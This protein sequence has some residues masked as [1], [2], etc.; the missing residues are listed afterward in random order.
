LNIQTERLE[1]QHAARLTVEIDQERLDK[2]KQKAAKQL[3]TRANIPGFRKGKAPYSIIVRYFGEAAIIQDAFELV[4]N[5][6]YRDALA[7]SGI[8]PYTSG[9]FEDFKLEPTPTLV[10]TVPLQPEVDLAGYRSVRVPYENAEVTDTDVTNAIKTLQEQ[11]AL[12]EDSAHPAK[13]GDRVTVDIHSHFVEEHEDEEVEEDASESEDAEPAADEHEEH[14]HDEHDHDH[15][16]GHGDDE[17]FIHEHDAPIIFDSEHE[18]LAG[19]NEAML[20]ANVGD[21]REFDL[22]IP[23]DSEEY[24]DVAGRQVHFGVTVKK[25]ENI[26]LPALNDEFAA[27]VTAEEEKPLTLLELRIRVREN[28]ERMAEERQDNEYARQAL[29]AMVDQATVK[30]PEEII[31]DEVENMLEQFDQQLRQ[32]GF[33]LK[34]YKALT[35]I[36][37]DDLFTQYRPTAENRVKRGLVMREVMVVEAIEADDAALHVEIDRLLENFDPSQRD[38]L[39]PMFEEPKMRVS[40]LD[41]LLRRLTTERI[42]AIAKGEAPELPPAVDLEVDDEKQ[43]NDSS[44]PEVVEAV[45]EEINQK[46]EAV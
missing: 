43:P 17:V 11:N 21:S 18:P 36:S 29:D 42:I 24:E 32:Q 14:D 7:E 39:R 15:H 40:V 23:D 38:N 19:F 30:F 26:T 37:D 9:A 31:A 2:A 44:K 33:T 20:G 12:T 5:D 10:F 25:I 41:D 28:L 45:N 13:L 1:D 16:H 6:V 3:S 4:S 22:T 35:K 34:D 8:E 46:G 27:K